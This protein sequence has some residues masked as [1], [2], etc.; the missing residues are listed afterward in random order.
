MATLHSKFVDGLLSKYNL[1]ENDLKDYIEN[2]DRQHILEGNNFCVCGHRIRNARYLMHRDGIQTE[3]DELM[4]GTCCIMQFCDKEQRGKHCEKCKAKHNNRLDNLCNTC[5]K[6]CTNDN[7]NGTRRINTNVCTKCYFY[8]LN[9]HN[10]ANG[11]TK[12]CKDCGRDSKQFIRCYNCN[13]KNGLK[14]K[15]G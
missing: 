10:I 3:I 6:L 12:K 1:T 8:E 9:K 13:A 5:R 15:N 11:I 4:I 2:P 14:N 7:C